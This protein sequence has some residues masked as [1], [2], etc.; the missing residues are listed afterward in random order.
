MD[1]CIERE[2]QRTSAQESSHDPQDAGDP[3]RVAHGGDGG[4]MA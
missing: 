3:T 2:E 1:D 4:G